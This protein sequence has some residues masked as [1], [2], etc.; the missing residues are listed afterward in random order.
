MGGLRV[1]DQPVEDV[2]REQSTVPHDGPRGTRRTLRPAARVGVDLVVE[3]EVSVKFAHSPSIRR[4]VIGDEHEGASAQP[5]QV[6]EHSTSRSRV[7]TAKPSRWSCR[8]AL[9]LDG[10]AAS[11]PS[12]RRGVEA[13]DEPR[14]LSHGGG[15]PEREVLREL[16][17][18]EVVED[19]RFLETGEPVQG[20]VMKE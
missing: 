2:D 20:H 8:K 9:R 16:E 3:F 10:R 15:D 11:R 13:V 4:M 19:D 7:P 6:L 14:P 17:S 5:E 18:L 1:A 12:V